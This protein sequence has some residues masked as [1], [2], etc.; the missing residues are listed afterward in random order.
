MS[1]KLQERYEISQ[2]QSLL[3]KCFSSWS[4]KLLIL[5][6]WKS[7]IS[8]INLLLC[9]AFWISCFSFITSRIRCLNFSSSAPTSSFLMFYLFYFSIRNARFF[10]NVYETTGKLFIFHFVQLNERPIVSFIFWNLLFPSDFA[11]C[12]NCIVEFKR[13]SFRRIRPNN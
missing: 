1:F 10:L 7:S 11:G 3:C 6:S 5:F 8:L 4:K 12:W 2:S 13:L 9:W